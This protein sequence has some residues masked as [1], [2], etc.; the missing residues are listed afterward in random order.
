MRRR[1]PLDGSHRW[2]E[3]VCAGSARTLADSFA[4]MLEIVS[5]LLSALRD[6]SL[7]DCSIQWVMQEHFN[8]SERSLAQALK[9]VTELQNRAADCTLAPACEKE[10]AQWS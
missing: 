4:D 5:R 8:L 6:S 3:T 7:A 9:E 2:S 1:D 10:I